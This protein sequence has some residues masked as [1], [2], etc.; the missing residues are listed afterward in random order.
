MTTRPN[1]PPL[2]R[3]RSR[4]AAVGVW[5]WRLANTALLVL[6]VWVLWRQAMALEALNAALLGLTDYLHVIAEGVR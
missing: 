4:L 6:A 3:R 1:P 2:R 5:L